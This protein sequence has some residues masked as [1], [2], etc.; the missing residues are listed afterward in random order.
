LALIEVETPELLLLAPLFITLTLMGHYLAHR[1]K[2]SLEVYHYPPVQRLIRI[3]AKQG[4]RRSQW[5]G[6]SLALKLVIVI[7]ITLCLSGPTLWTFGEKSETVEVPM[8]MEKDV[9]GQIILAI[10]VS[11][12]M[13]LSDVYPSRLEAAKNALAR[14]VENSS[15]NVRFGVVAFERDIRRMLPLTENKSRV[16]STIQQLS[17]SEV[18]PCLEEFT[19]IGYGLQTCVDVLTPYSSSNKSSALILV[20]DGFANYGYPTPFKSVSAAVTRANNTGIPIHALHV[21]RMGQDSNDKLMRQIADE[22]HG[23]FMD[24]ISSEELANVLDIIGKYYVP[25]HEWSSVIE[26]K[27]TI[28]R[29]TELGF[30]LMLI[31]TA[32]ILALWFG[33]YKHYKTSF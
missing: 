33:N 14:F 25:T 30:F 4:L 2:T 27:I 26:I 29:R 19:D 15:E 18:L 17:P 21:A 6:V 23:K 7:L 28:P 16:V 8:I 22:T 9:A 3:V 13:R 20:S 10:D 5:R 11:G 24:S 1:I 12:S 32:F 31:A